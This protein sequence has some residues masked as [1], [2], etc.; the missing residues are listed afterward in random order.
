MN[1]DA[2]DN[3]C[4]SVDSVVVGMGFPH[5]RKLDPPVVGGGGDCADHQPGDG[6]KSGITTRPV[7]MLPVSP[8]EVGS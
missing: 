1:Q 6:P 7:V 3:F 5:S 8:A 4:D 2:L